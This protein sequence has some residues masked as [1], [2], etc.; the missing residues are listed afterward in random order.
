V[1]D[2]VIGGTAR[3]VEGVAAFVE[4]PSGR[5]IHAA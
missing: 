5:R 3:E 2:M 4:E 1:T